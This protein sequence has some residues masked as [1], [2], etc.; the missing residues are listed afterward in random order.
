MVDPRDSK[1]ARVRVYR[2]VVDAERQEGPQ[3]SSKQQ[4]QKKEPAA[5]GAQNRLH[6]TATKTSK[7]RQL[8]QQ[9]SIGAG[10]GCS[11]TPP[12]GDHS[13]SHGRQG[14]QK[15]TLAMRRQ[16]QIPAYN[17]DL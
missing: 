10:V 16:F 3:V 15:D 7:D 11:R 6:S 8:Q 5:A 17:S 13:S 1:P 12:E 4:E 9:L 2:H 14:D